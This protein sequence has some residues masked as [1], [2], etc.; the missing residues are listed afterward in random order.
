[1]KKVLLTAAAVFAFG[2]TNAQEIKFGA[3]A[4]LNLSTIKAT[5]PSIN[6][7]IV[8]APDN[9]MAVG[10]HVGGFAEIGITEKFAF[11]PE[12]LFSME[13][14]KF[15]ANESGSETFGGDTYTY[16][17]VNKT[18][19]KTSYINIPLLAKFKATEKLFFV[20]G[21]Q[22]GF[23]MSAKRD[24]TNTYSETFN[25]TTETETTSVNGVDIK[26]DLKGVNFALDLGAGY[27]FTDN[28]FAEARYN[29]G[30]SNDAKE[31]KETFN[32]VEYS[33][34]PVYKA[35]SIQISFGYKF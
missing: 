32:G 8:I 30:L 33:Y 14:S 34:Q 35:S 18:T 25:G 9:K 11:Q 20:A 19:V 24:Y 6:G 10:F 7:A 23:L 13:G 1:M 31:V 12:L 2:F 21:P 28:I 3:K 27:F 4:G 15:E 17:D 29:I 26:K 5:P 22:L 16:S